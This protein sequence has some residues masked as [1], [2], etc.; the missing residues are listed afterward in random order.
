RT[1]DPQTTDRAL[2]TIERNAKLQTQLIEDLLDVSRILRGKLLLNVA[3]V[4]LTTT[5]QAALETVRLTAEAKNIQIQ[6]AFAPDIDLVSGDAARLQ[7]IVWNLLSNAVKFTPEGGR[8]EVSLSQVDSGQE[9]R[10]AEGMPHWASF[11]QICVT[12][13]GKGI[14]PNFLPYVFDSFRQEDGKTTRKFGGLGLGLAIVRHL[15][16]LHGGSVQAE[17][18]GDGHGAKFTVRLPLPDARKPRGSK[19]SLLMPDSSVLAGLRILAVD[20]EPD[21][22]ELLLTILEQNGIEVR[23][24]ASA[25]EALDALEQFQPDVLISDVGMPEMDGYALIRQIRLLPDLATLPAI[26]LTAY[27]GEIDQQQALQAGFQHHLAKPVEPDQLI[28]VIAAL[29]Q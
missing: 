14:D 26:A 28:Q 3:P 1:F 16:E 2:E 13:T 22:R 25:T 6:T 15:V 4:N 9:G 5:I 19:G 17:S 12:D 7:Q 11:A 8:V 24:A 20:D 10:D 29:V 27:A 23:A 18:L 21:M